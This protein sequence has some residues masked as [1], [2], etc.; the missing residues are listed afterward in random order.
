MGHAERLCV[1]CADGR[2][3]TLYE[4]D[5]VPVGVSWCGIC[6]VYSRWIRTFL[7]DATVQCDEGCICTVLPEACFSVDTVWTLLLIALTGP[8]C[9][10]Y[11]PLSE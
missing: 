9:P 1:G 4:Y 10:V 3:E 6:G 11:V 7:G 5:D 2:D 8:M